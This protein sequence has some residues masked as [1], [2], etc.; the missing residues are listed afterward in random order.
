M[1]QEFI[2]GFGRATNSHPAFLQEMYRRL[3]GDCSANGTTDQAKV[4]ERIAELLQHE[5]VDVWDLRL[6]NQGRPEEY[7]MFLEHC[8]QYIES[9]VSTAVDDRRH[10]SVSENDVVT[11]LA[12]SFSVGDLHENVATRCPSETPI[13]SIQWLRL[14][15][16]PKQSN[17][18]FAKRQ[19]GK[20]NLKLMV[21]SRQFRKQHIDSHYASSLFC[22]EREFAIT[23]RE[24]CLM[25]CMDD[26]HTIKVGEPHYPVAAVERGTQVLVTTSKKL[27]VAD[28]D[29]TKFSLSPSV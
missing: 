25:I 8:K 4:D 10:D 29:F 13:P 6:N 26:K 14:Q 2:H 28:H 7:H 17:C 16:W 27:V 1:R 12:T 21:Q 5:D 18:G 23:F 3:T 20:L 9:Q 15:F 24:H 19:T 22:Y 11:H